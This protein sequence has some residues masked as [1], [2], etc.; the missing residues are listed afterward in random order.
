M[1]RIVSKL[2]AFLTE[3]NE[4]PK[5]FIKTALI[6]LAIVTIWGLIMGIMGEYR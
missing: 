4:S 1:K 3:F 6:T 2:I 5:D